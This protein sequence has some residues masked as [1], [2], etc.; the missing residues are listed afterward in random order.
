[1]KINYT[2]P[3]GNIHNKLNVKQDNTEQ[4]NKVYK[5]IPISNNMIS[6][7]I[8]RSQVVSFCGENRLRG[9]IFEH[10]C[11]EFLGDRENISY[12][13]EDGSFRHT[14]LSRDGILKKQEEFFPLENKE[15]ITRV[16]DGIKSVTTKT[17]NTY[18]LEK[19]NET[20]DQIYFEKTSAYSKEVVINDFDKGRRIISKEINGRKFVDV[21]DLKTNRSVTS[22]DMV[23][24]RVYDKQSD[25]YITENLITG[26]VLKREKYRSNG[27]Y[28]SVIEY[29][30]ETGNIRREYIYDGRTGGY[31]DTT[32]SDSGYRKTLV[33]ISRDGR[34]EDTYNFTR[35]GQTVASRVLFEYDKKGNLECESV[36]IPGTDLIDNQTLYSTDSCTKYKFRKTPNVPI[37]AE[38]YEDGR[39]VEEIRFHSNG[40]YYE[41][42][43]QYK[44]DGS[45][46]EN[47][48]DRYG[49]QTHSK[50]YTVDNILYQVAEYNPDTN[51]VI[52]SINIDI[53]TGATKET[54]YDEET[55]YTKRVIYRDSN[56]KVKQIKDYFIGTKIIKHL[57][58]YNPDGSYWYTEFD[59]FGAVINKEER[60]PDGSRKEYGSYNQDNNQYY[61]NYTYTWSTTSSKSKENILSDDQVIEHVL[62]VT[63]SVAKSISEITSQEW[64]Q[65]TKILGLDSTDELLNMSKETFRKLSKRFHPD[66]QQDEAKKEYGEKIFKI[67]QNLY[68]RNSV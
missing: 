10:N 59:Q 39:L 41:Y 32:Y 42:S 60:N 55:G 23:L 51:E 62:S 53:N 37:Y 34:K 44:E 46:R 38:H 56:G 20:G 17:P 8:G 66:L 21:I 33:K 24:Q 30:P 61:S 5:N 43:K 18:I 19:Y 50:S 68:A 3:I 7:V 12:N 45:Y 49:G 9:A 11:S 28:E 22:G 6:E 54:L 47:F 65:L 16:S 15:I 4:N 26:Q 13:K 35:D 67:I 1:M 48:F 2:K 40:K 29:S 57:F 27:K 63:S 25:S 64:S 52:R 36:Y 31:S 14:I 58:E